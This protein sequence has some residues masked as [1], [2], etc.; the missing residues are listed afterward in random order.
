MQLTTGSESDDPRRG[1]RKRVDQA[2]VRKTR[3]E[4]VV[5]LEEKDVLDQRVLEDGYTLRKRSVWIREMCGL[6]GVLDDD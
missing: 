1:R 4:F 2:Q 5:T 3:I 6:K